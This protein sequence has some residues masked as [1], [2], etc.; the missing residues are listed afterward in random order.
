MEPIS[1]KNSAVVLYSYVLELSK[2]IYE[3]ELRYEDS[4]IKQSS[5]MQVA[6]SF[7][8]AALFAGVQVIMKYSINQLSKEFFLLAVSSVA[9]CLLISLVTA[10]LA[11]WRALTETFPDISVLE[12]SVSK[13]WK[14]NLKEEVR[15]KKH[16][17]LLKKIQESKA[18]K[19]KRRVMLVIAS[20][21]SFLISLG[22]IVF[23]FFAGIIKI[24]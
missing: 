22:L 2:E 24:I 13:D 17:D 15:I 6:F 23:W 3:N 12:D 21:I 11:Q 20:M 1:T 18:K 7:V 5:Q 9:F 19:Y 10:T 14:N 8:I 4:I 16:I